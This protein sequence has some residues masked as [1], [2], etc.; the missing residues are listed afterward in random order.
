[1]PASQRSLLITDAYR[2][3][4][5]GLRQRAMLATSQAWTSTIDFSD[6]DDSFRRWHI[7][8]VAMTTAAQAQAAQLSDGY[9]SAFST[10][11]LGQYVPPVGLDP[12]KYAG[13]T[14]WGRPVAALLAPSLIV[15]KAAIGDGR[16]PDEASRFGMGRAVQ[17]VASQTDGAGRAALSDAMVESKHVDGWR[18]VTGSAP[19]GACLAEATGDVMDPSEDLGVH[20]FCSCT[21][22]PVIA[23]VPDDVQRP[24]GQDLFDS[25]SDQ[26]QDDLFAGRGGSDKAD[27][28]RSGDVPL[29]A[30]ITHSDQVSGQTVLTETPL[31]ALR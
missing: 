3:R 18:R 23:D 30:L 28:I 9:L 10:S 24:T 12:A 5:V 8:A 13:V 19:C 15:V 21:K 16:T 29:S 4:T 14:D 11:E 31:K 27:L 17:N 1:M 2:S 7:G 25:M 26:E 22:E 6:L 20:P